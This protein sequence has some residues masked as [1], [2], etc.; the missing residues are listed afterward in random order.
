MT[1]ARET[2]RSF[3]VSLARWNASLALRFALSF[4][5][6]QKRPFRGRVQPAGEVVTVEG[7][8]A[9]RV[10]WD[11]SGLHMVAHTPRGGALVKHLRGVSKALEVELVEGDDV[12]CRACWHWT[13]AECSICNHCGG[14]A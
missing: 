3:R 1:A 2:R 14:K 5:P 13:D 8:G 7:V 10:R 4:A 6:R 12:R 9:R 11:L